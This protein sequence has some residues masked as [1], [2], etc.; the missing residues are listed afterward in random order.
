MYR[1]E[2]H[3]PDMSGTPSGVPSAAEGFGRELMRAR[4]RTRERL[5]TMDDCKRR[6]CACGE[7][8]RNAWEQP[9]VFGDRNT[10]AQGRHV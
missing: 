9:G 10:D 5:M 3:A 8:E 7:T 2:T 6:P 1:C 4:E